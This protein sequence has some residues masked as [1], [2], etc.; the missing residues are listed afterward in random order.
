METSVG[1]RGSKSIITFI[2]NFFKFKDKTGYKSRR[3]T[4]QMNTI[5]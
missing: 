1:V 3:N 5:R 2:I 4:K